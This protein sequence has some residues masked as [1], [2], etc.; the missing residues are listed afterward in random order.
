MILE[1]Y[2]WS[3]A[4]RVHTDRFLCLARSNNVKMR[5]C[6]PKSKHSTWKPHYADR[7]S[8]CCAIVHL[9]RVG[10]PPTPDPL[11]TMRQT[12][13]AFMLLGVAV[14][15][16]D[17]FAGVVGLL[18]SIQLPSPLSS[19]GVNRGHMLSTSGRTTSGRTV[20][21]GPARAGKAWKRARV[22][23]MATE[24][25]DTGVGFMMLHL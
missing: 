24:E 7:V 8:T 4:L 19:V 13:I 6:E 1:L 16:A 3:R 11:C 17:A 23:L 20:S 2:N 22:V 25:V 15:C 10:E 12:L 5:R 21:S 14:P 9:S 18:R